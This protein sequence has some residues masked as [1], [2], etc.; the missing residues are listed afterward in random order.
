MRRLV[1]ALVV[2]SIMATATV[3]GPPTTDTSSTRGIG[4]ASASA[5]EIGGT[6]YCGPWHRAWYVSRSGWWYFW[7]WRW[8]YNPSILGG[9]YRDWAGWHWDVFAGPG[10]RSGFQYDTGPFPFGTG[11]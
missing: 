3:A 2:L 7:W 6:V 10:F 8:C 9:W 4:P 1:V 11:P 5:Q